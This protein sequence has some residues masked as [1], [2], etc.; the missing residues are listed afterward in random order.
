MCIERKRKNE[1]L[2]AQ[3]TRIERKAHLKLY[4]LCI[5]PNI[6]NLN[7]LN[8]VWLSLTDIKKKH[9]NLKGV[10]SSFFSL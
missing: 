10:Q 9:Q 5:S 1:I 2:R 4:F 6:S 8:L 3:T 7:S